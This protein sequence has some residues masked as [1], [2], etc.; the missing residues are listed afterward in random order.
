MAKNTIK[1]KK[2]ADIINEYDAGGTIKP[3]HLLALN[4]DNAVVVD[5]SAGVGNSKMFA[6]EDE[7]QGKGIDDNY[8]SGDKVQVWNTI[9]GEEV[10]ALLADGEDVAVGDKL[11]SAGDGTLKKM[12]ADS[13][14]TVVEEVPVAVVITEAVDMSGSSGAD[15]SGRVKVRII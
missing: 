11:V 13:S 6:L 1:L 9:P 10:Y 14:A 8:V 15:P 12:T 7:L 3:G 2:Y 5:S 4:S